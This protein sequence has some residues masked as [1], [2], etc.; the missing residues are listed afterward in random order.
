L[1]HEGHS[2]TIVGIE[3][4]LVGREQR[5]E[6]TLLILDPSTP[7]S[8]LA[9]ALANRTGWQRLL[10]RGAHTLR[11]QQYQLL[12]VEPGIAAGAQLDALKMLA[13]VERY[14]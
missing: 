10:K 4:R 7:G 1:Q 14:S 2:R 8:K 3:R 12:F 13:A 6:F 5:A 11:N 9:A